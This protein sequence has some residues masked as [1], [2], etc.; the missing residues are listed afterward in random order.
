MS[1]RLLRSL[2]GRMPD[3][4]DVE[5]VTLRGEAGFEVSIITFGAA[6][7]A[8]Q[9]PDRKGRRD[10]VVL[11]HDTLEPY[12]L[13]RN[14]FGATVGRYA[15]RIAGA[16]FTLDGIRH[17]LSANDGSNTLHGGTDGFDRMLWTIAGLDDGPMPF[18]TLSYVSPD[19]AGGFPGTLMVEIRFQLTGPHELSVSIEASTDRETV[20]SLTHHSYF[21]LGG[22]VAGGDILDHELTLF[23]DRYLP[24]DSGLIPLG[25]P[26]RVD[27][28]P[29]DFQA[30]RTIGA[31]IRAEDEQLRRARGY[32]HC[33]VLGD[34]VAVAPRLAAQVVH[35]NSGRTLDL[36]TD[37]P[38][39]QFYSGNSLG[40]VSGG[41][42]GRLYRQ[43]DAFCLEPQAW[44]NAPNRPDYPSTRLKTGSSYHQSTAY[45]FHAV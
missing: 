28:T 30:P 39:L 38:G 18:V 27:G 19:G 44:P 2:F 35:P 25:A 22:A 23:A 45:R 6:V 29:F 32:D 1:G 12:L 3:G 14:F 34:E 26:S 24:I 40:G 11:G 17:Q 7:Q 10:D 13:R 33:F 43:F 21:N 9:V 31:A 36:I 41:K 8:L 20:V 42:G 37:Q 15:N 16:S 4:A 5:R